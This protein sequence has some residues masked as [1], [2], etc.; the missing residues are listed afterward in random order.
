MH[1]EKP[2]DPGET[3]VFTNTHCR[4]DAVQPNAMHPVEIDGR[5]LILAR[6][7]EQLVAFNG[8]CPHASADLSAGRLTRFKVICP[9]HG[10]CFDIRNG[11]ILW[12]EDEVYRL[13]RYPLQIIDGFIWVQ[14]P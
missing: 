4:A 14:L 1:P 11:R 12:P 3:A 6:Y 10:Y 8:R 5:C 7:A 13:K 2:T 9:D